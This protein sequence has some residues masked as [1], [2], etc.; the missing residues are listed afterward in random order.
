MIK[1]DDNNDDDSLKVVAPPKEASTFSPLSAG[2]RGCNLFVLQVHA[3]V[4][5]VD[6]H[7]SIFLGSRQVGAWGRVLREGDLPCAHAGKAKQR[8]AGWKRESAWGGARRPIL[9]GQNSPASPPTAVVRRCW[10]RKL[11]KSNLC[12][13]AADPRRNCGLAGREEW[14]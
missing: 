8:K 3:D 6:H 7:G 13:T 11:E 9:V 10:T 5:A 2:C 12:K 14:D 4:P 1:R